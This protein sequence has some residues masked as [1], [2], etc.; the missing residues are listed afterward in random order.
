MKY[1]WIIWAIL[2]LVLTIV[3][4]ISGIYN[5][6]YCDFKH[7]GILGISAM[8]FCSSFCSSIQNLRS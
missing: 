3:C 7:S 4:Y 1:F 8:I 5:C 6:L 2:M